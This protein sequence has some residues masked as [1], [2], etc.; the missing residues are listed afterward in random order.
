L[1]LFHNFLSRN[2]SKSYKVSKD[3]FSLVYKKTGAKYYYLAQGF[4]RRFRKRPK[5]GP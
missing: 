5:L 2:L 3:S 4:L 1:F